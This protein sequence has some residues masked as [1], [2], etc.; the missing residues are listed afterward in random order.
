MGIFGKKHISLELVISFHCMLSF[1][2]HS[3]EEACESSH[4]VVPFNNFAFCTMA[5]HDNYETEH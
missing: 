1:T 3:E 5:Y 2:D 4:T